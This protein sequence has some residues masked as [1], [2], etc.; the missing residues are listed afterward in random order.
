MSGVK[1]SGFDIFGVLA[2]G[3]FPQIEDAGNLQLKTC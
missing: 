2:Q 1:N 3:D